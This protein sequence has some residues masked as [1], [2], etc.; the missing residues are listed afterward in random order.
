[1]SLCRSPV[2]A[3]TGQDRS[4]RSRAPVTLPDAPRAR[5]SRRS[6]E[7]PHEVA[8][9]GLVTSTGSASALARDREGHVTATSWSDRKVPVGAIDLRSIARGQA[10]GG[11]RQG[12]HGHGDE[13]ASA[14][15]GGRAQTRRGRSGWYEHRFT[16]ASATGRGA[17]EPAVAGAER[18]CPA[19]SR[20]AA[21]I[22]RLAAAADSTQDRVARGSAEGLPARGSPSAF[23]GKTLETNKTVLSML[24][25]FLLGRTGD[26]RRKIGFR[27]PATGRHRRHSNGDGSDA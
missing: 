17:V 8:N 21:R 13:R 20:P 15:S 27:G 7:A 9:V 5:I 11:R 4:R 12:G 2:T 25:R 16:G 14:R 22:N 6:P 19:V 18:R 1:M 24:D 3:R 23:P 26:L 10:R